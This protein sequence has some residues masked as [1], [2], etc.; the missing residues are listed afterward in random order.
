VK[1]GGEQSGGFELLL[2]EATGRC[3]PTDASWCSAATRRTWAQIDPNSLENTFLHDRASGTTEL[4]SV[5]S[6]N[7][8]GDGL[9]HPVGISADGRYVAM[10]SYA[11]NLAPGDTNGVVDLFV[12]DRATRVTTRESVASDGTQGNGHSFGG[13]MSDDGRF[14]AFYGVA[15]TL[16][17][18]DTN[19]DGSFSLRTDPGQ[20]VFVRDRVLGVT[21]RVSLDLNG[22]QST[23]RSNDSKISADGRFV[24]FDYGGALVP[25]DNGAWDSYVRDRAAGTTVR[26][27][28]DS[29]GRQGSL[30]SD[31]LA[32]GSFATVVSGNGR[33]VGFYSNSGNLTG[34]SDSSARLPFVEAFVHDTVTQITSRMS[35]PLDGGLLDADCGW[36][37]GISADGRYMVM[38]CNATNL[39]SDDTNGTLDVFVRGPDLA[40][41]AAGLRG[42]DLADTVLQVLGRRRRHCPPLCPATQVAI[43]PGGLLRPER[44]GGAPGC[45][46]LPLNDADATDADESSTFGRNGASLGL[47]ARGSGSD[48][49][50]AAHTRSTR[51]RRSNGDGDVDDT[52][53]QI[54]PL[55]VAVDQPRAAVSPRSA[56]ASSRLRRARPGQPGPERGW[57]R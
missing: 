36:P 40:D 44:A 41:C 3:R 9:T 18:G 5:N 29:S 23:A 8:P 12:R 25:G 38:C 53:V 35:V 22:E 57:R 55:A 28:V 2:A 45:P 7:V 16:V 4:V 54:R 24:A 20:D 17:P 15:D 42:C 32:I 13:T 47:S 14:I 46:A 11:T 37:A 1:S 27:S 30:P 19:G 48:S 10:S 21:E 52:V 50:L 43:A 26:A 34:A 33:F 6:Q 56:T 51:R 49:W 39:I 31:P